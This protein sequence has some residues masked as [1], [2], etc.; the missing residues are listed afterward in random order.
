M[1]HGV[2]CM[3]HG[4]LCMVYGIIMIYN[5]WFS[6]SNIHTRV[7]HAPHINAL[8]YYRLTNHVHLPST[9]G[10]QIVWFWVLVFITG[11]NMILAVTITT[12]TSSKGQCR[13]ALVRPV[14]TITVTDTGIYVCS[15][16]PF[17]KRCGERTVMGKGRGVC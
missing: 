3:M 2:W 9:P 6:F 5:N 11:S 7:S 16:V 13:E 14:L 4:V 12:T 17:R 1:V 15:F 10:A 8:S